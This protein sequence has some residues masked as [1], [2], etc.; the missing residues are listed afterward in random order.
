MWHLE[1]VDTDCVEAF[2]DKGLFSSLSVHFLNI[3][4]EKHKMTIV[5]LHCLVLATLERK[6]TAR[7]NQWY[8]WNDMIISVHRCCPNTSV[9]WRLD[10]VTTWTQP[11]YYIPKTFLSSILDAK[12]DA[13]DD[14]T[15]ILLLSINKPSLLNLDCSGFVL[16]SKKRF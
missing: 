6:T 10:G 3:H 9:R 12:M 2:D 1:K 8:S 14:D 7:T 5:Y 11:L 15:L 13:L 16:R 4:F